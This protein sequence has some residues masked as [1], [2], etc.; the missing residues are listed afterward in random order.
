M[1]NSDKPNPKKSNSKKPNSDKRNQH[2]PAT[3]EDF[4]EPKSRSQIKRDMLALQALGKR[5][6]DLNKQQLEQVP[7]H[8]SLANAVSEYQRLKS[9]S[10]KR[11]Q[12][13]YIGKLM[14]DIDP[15]EIETA[16]ARF[17]ASTAEH[18]RH[19]HLLEQWRDR[20]LQD[21][22]ALTQFMNDFP[23]TDVQRLRQLVRNAQKEIK[24][25]KNLGHSKKLFRYIREIAEND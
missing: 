14:R 8:D 12:M 19:F 17:D 25:E 21:S 3:D 1:S 6:T 20:L 24:Q 13:Q 4:D 5:L 9:N 11:R 23:A 22:Q 7:M 2:D 16:L 15:T 18:N 10:A